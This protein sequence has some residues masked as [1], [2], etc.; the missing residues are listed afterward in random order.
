MPAGMPV[1]YTPQARDQYDEKIDVPMKWSAKPGGAI[2]VRTAYGAGQHFAQARQPGE[3]AISPDGL[4]TGTKAGAVTITLSSDADPAITATAMAGVGDY[5]AV[6]PASKLPLCI[7]N[8]RDAMVGDIDRLRLY[9][10]VMPAE[11]AAANAAGQK[12][13][14]EGLIADWTFDDLKDGAYANVAGQGLEARVVCEVEHVEDKDGRYV[15]LAR[16]GWLEVAPDSRLDA[17]AALTLEW[18]VR[19]TGPGILIVRQVVWQWGMI[20]RVDPNAVM[21]DAFRTDGGTLQA[22]FDFPKEGWT[23]LVVAFGPSGAWKMYAN[24]KL[25]GERLAMPAPVR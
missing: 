7:G 19:P 25:I 11:E 5:H 9:A 1:R 15:R 18:W 10:R 13:K 17:S 21:A 20:V 2:D 4:F 24:G 3:G 23:H 6:Y 8:E 14:D 12:P 22:P 16:K